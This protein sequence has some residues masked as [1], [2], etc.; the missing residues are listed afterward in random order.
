VTGKVIGP[1]RGDLS[2]ERMQGSRLKKPAKS[3]LLEIRVTEYERRWQKKWLLDPRSEYLSFLGVE[4]PY[5]SWVLKGVSQNE[6]NPLR[7]IET[8]SFV[9]W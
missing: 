3:M 9:V 1:K 7:G 2:G 8:T 4:K 6:M 5:G